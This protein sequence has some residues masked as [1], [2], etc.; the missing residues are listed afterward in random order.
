VAVIRRHRRLAGGFAVALVLAGF[1]VAARPGTVVAHAV[2]V[3]SSPESQA[4]LREAPPV[5]DLWFSEPLEPEFSR[6]ELYASD[7]TQLELAGMRVDP[8]DAQHLSA[9]TGG[10]GP[11]IYTVVYRTLS[12]RDGHEWSGSTTFTVVNPD[13]SAPVGG[14][15]TPDLDAGTSADEVAGR[16]LVF[17]AFSV[18]V[19]G[20]L[21]AM[22][23]ALE[24]ERAPVARR[25]RR[26]AVRLGVAAL[27]LAVGGSLLQL[28]ARADALGGSELDLLSGTRFGTILLWRGLALLAAVAALGL[29][30]LA[31]RR[32]RERL[33]R[34]FASVAAITVLGGLA[35]IPLLSHAAAAPGS[36]WAILGDT[37]HLVLAAAWVGGLLVLAAL[38]LS[39][40]RGGG[41]R[42]GRLVARFSLFATGALGLLAATGLLRA[43]GEIPTAGALFETEYGA[44]LLIKLGLLLV[45]LAV[46]LRNRANLEL[47]RQ[48]EVDEDELHDELRRTLPLEAGL[49]LLVLGTVAVLGQVP[50]PRGDEVSA[51]TARTVATDV[52]LIEQVDD[53]TVHLQV[54]PAVVGSNELRLH[55][56][57]PD[58]SA[59]GTVDRVQ[60]E[61]AA[62]AATGGGDVVEPVPEGDD[63]YRATATASSLAVEWSVSVDVRR[64]GID[65]AR[66][67][68]RVP[69]QVDPGTEAGAG[70]YGS[71]APQL[72]RNFLWALLLMPVGAS[73]LVLGASR[74][75]REVTPRRRP[76]GA[77]W[78]W[79]PG[80]PARAA[81]PIPSL[82][83]AGAAVV[84][85]A[86]VLGVSGSPHSHGSQ[87]L[88]N[89]VANDPA[90]FERGRAIYAA[91]CTSCH[92]VDG[93]GN[94]PL[95]ATLT[96][97]PA[98]LALHVP[99]HPEGDTYI[100]IANGFPNTAMPA[101]SGTLSEEEIWDVVNYLRTEFAE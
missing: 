34:G 7:G 89:P 71:P 42:L 20:A 63:I 60:L 22:L 35:T 17:A 16:W 36:F 19:G 85:G 99:L 75:R 48:R 1:A 92:G 86:I 67:A 52:N 66:L 82:R 13:G 30:L 56:Y 41:A 84:L 3:R 96:P 72:S 8:A 15:Y 43:A 5:I 76:R 31:A 46:A 21:I 10:L 55:L 37:L 12:T 45:P 64:A 53:L 18:L 57:H 91:N 4:Q 29:S 9:L 68:F 87:L 81:L 94:G 61:L 14:G 79:R 74:H 32:R 40:R 51:A 95:A 100:F 88:E 27:P 47:W 54:S 59:I 24:G 93:L 65:D 44:W 58:G 101:W 23:G 77:P 98:N 26:L 49:A 78:R 90:S 80:R 38:L 25:A 97:Q 2:L 33:E 69:I 83:A 50:T 11:G 73:L 28:V 39:S 6:F 62:G 70:Q